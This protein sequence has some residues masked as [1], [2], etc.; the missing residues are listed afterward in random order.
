MYLA[1][2]DGAPRFP[3][4]SSDPTILRIPLR[5]DFV[6]LTGLSP[7]LAGLPIPFCYKIRSHIEVL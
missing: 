6:S 2:D 7:S 1:L 3:Q 5:P 4:G